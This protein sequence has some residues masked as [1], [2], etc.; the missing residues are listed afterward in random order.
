[1]KTILYI[2]TAL[3]ALISSPA[4]AADGGADLDTLVVTANRTPVR[5]DQVG[6][7]ITVID[8]DQIRARQTPVITDLLLSVPGVSLSRNG[9]V[10]TATQL[11][12]R[13][14]ETGQT[15][16]LIDGVKLNDP[17][18]TDSGY[19]AGNLL[20]G[21]VARIEVLRG[22]QSVLWGSQAIGG[23]INIITADPTEPFEAD[24]AV[25]GGSFKTAS[26]RVGLGGKSERV[27]WRAAASS[28]TTDGVSAF[29]RARGGREDDGYH[30]L[31]ASGKAAVLLTDQLSLDLRAVYSRGRTKIDGF[32]TPTGAF[33]DDAE[34]S[35]TRDVIGYAGLRLDLLDGR[36]SNR[37]AVAYTD[38]AR[39]SFN[40]LQRVTT[41]TFDAAGRNRRFEYQGTLKL[42]PA[43]IAVFGAESERSRFRTASPSPTNPTPVPGHR[44]ASLDGLYGQVSGQVLPDLTLAGG[45]RYDDH[46][47]F[48]G[49]TVGQASAAWTIAGA[50]TLRA[51]IG[52]GFKAPS[53]FQ[54][55]SDF[56][57]GALNPEAARSW[58]A[59]VEQRLA[60]GRVTLS[61]AYFERHTK[62]QIDFVSCTATSTAALCFGGNGLRRSG[63]YDNI[64]RSKAHGWELQAQAEPVDGLRLSA[65]YSY[66]ASL[67]DVVGAA[68]FGKWL[69]R[70]PRNQ[71]NFE[72]SYVWPVR[73]TTAVAARY[74]G[75]SFDDA[76]NRNLSK[77]YTLWDVRASFPVTDQIE[78]YGRVENLFDKNYETIRNYGQLGRAAYAGVRAR[79]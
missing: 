31:G 41:T 63:Y 9:G 5:A 51:S 50:T 36:L 34:F 44:R 21:D 29:N 25:E 12:I 13:G 28:Y 23:V 8:Q 76:A 15:V 39:G 16:V 40:P 67:N 71:A 53:L 75:H 66:T 78:V 26:A 69:A 61:A 1:M 55:G 32:A 43:W 22:V 14:A 45:V 35:T 27:T 59:G 54:L 70:R 4:M 60:D 49:H 68:N 18:A 2:S 77:T 62:N 57:N 47:D 58:D 24:A 37:L 46:G 7:Q 11:K 48:G 3:G 19:N 72:A 10:G 74:A 79:F 38:T 33:G 30:N 20:T 17:S 73:L 42:T 64:S 6:G 52:Q 65:N 56:G